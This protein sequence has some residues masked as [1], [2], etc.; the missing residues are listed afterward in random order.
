MNNKE[1]SNL[2]H[3]EWVKYKKE[4]RAALLNDYPNFNFDLR[5][6]I[7]KEFKHILEKEGITLYLANGALLGAVREKN[8]IAWDDDVDMDVLYE[9]LEPKYETI[10]EQLIDLGYI[11]RGINKYPEMKINIYHGGEKV[12]ILALYS[13][14]EFRI[15]GP[16]KWP[17]FL[18]ENPEKIVF[19]GE[20]FTA[21]Q[22][23][24][25]LKHQYGSDWRVP[26][27]KNYFNKDVFV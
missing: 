21:P 1:I 27:K 8:F 10:R 2:S 18:Y 12:G 5:F 23:I 7:I 20:T 3:A 11:V 14:G 22:I 17:S 26:K 9:E 6:E 19:K 16:Y 24:D 13:K 4:N 15:R 25:Y